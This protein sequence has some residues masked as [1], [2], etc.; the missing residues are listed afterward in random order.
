MYCVQDIR[1]RS[2]WPGWADMTNII[3]Y[4]IY[5]HRVLHYMPC[6]AMHYIK[7]ECMCMWCS[8]CWWYRASIHKPL[9]SP[10]FCAR[11][12]T[13]VCARVHNVDVGCC[14]CRCSGRSPLMLLYARCARMH[15]ASSL[16]RPWSDCNWILFSLVVNRA[17][18]D[19]EY[20]II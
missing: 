4:F 20:N 12:H 11:V 10:R 6:H 15:W 14:C 19:I 17:K 13:L 3:V 18:N 16:V 8:L 2:L 7:R 1:Q 9:S 5:T